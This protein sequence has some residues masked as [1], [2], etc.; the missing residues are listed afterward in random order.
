MYRS[1]WTWHYAHRRGVIQDESG[2][3]LAREEQDS[4]VRSQKKILGRNHL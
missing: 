4:G 3:P 2:P 1:Q